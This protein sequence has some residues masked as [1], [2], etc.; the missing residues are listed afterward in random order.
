MAKGN[1][2]LG[3]ARGSVGDVVMYR[4]NGAQVSRS[5]NRA[6]RNPQ[7]SRQ[8]FQRAIISTIA[9]AYAA[10]KDIFDH[11]FEGVSVPG[12]SQREFLSDN[13]R[14]LRDR[15]AADQANNIGGIYSD[16][17]VGPRATTPVHG[18]FVVSRGSLS[19]TF[20]SYNAPT[21]EGGTNEVSSITIPP[22]SADE[23]IGSYAT[24]NGLVPG[25]I[26]TFVMFGIKSSETMEGYNR[27]TRFFWQR[28]VVKDG[29]TE[30]TEAFAGKRMRDLFD[31]SQSWQAGVYRGYDVLLSAYTSTQGVPVGEMAL[32]PDNY[33]AA[34]FAIIRSR[35][36]SGLRSSAQMVFANYDDGGMLAYDELVDAWRAGVSL[37]ESELILEGGGF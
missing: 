11:S 26:Y 5:R 19:Q 22:A 4:A 34:S 7:S 14:G 15:I 37:G 16:P 6:P 31:I 29:I 35:E 18:R 23:T 8:I 12:G 21:G 30:S 3:Y 24:S 13:I 25:D 20:F 10:G 32:L 27:L 2:F 1:I 36:D 28:F 9:K 33:R 17:L